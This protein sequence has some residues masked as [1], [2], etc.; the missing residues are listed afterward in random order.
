[1]GAGSAPHYLP[2]ASA[3]VLVFVAY[4][5]GAKLGLA[6][7]FEP[8]PISVLWPPNAIL[9]AA[10]LVAPLRWWPLLIVAALPAHLLAELQGGVP[11]AMVVCWFLSNVSEALIGAGFM[12]A[13]I[14]GR[15]DLDSLR[16]VAAFVGAAVLAAFLSSFLDSAFVRLV[17]WGTADYWELWRSRFSS[18]VLATLTVAPVIVTWASGSFASLQVFTPT[19]LAE[20]AVLVLGL[21]VAGALVFA[22]PV[23][24]SGALPALLYLPVPFLLW[25][26]LRFGAAGTSAAFM[27]VA[28]LAIWG[29][30]HGRG[31]FADGAPVENAQAVQVF[32][33]FV[34]LMVLVLAAVVQERR[35]SE[36]RA[37]EANERLAHIS[38]L[39]VVGELTASIAH[40][41]NQPLGAILNN[42]DAAE[43]LLR[44]EDPHLDELRNIIDDIRKDDMR[45]GEVIRHMRSLL[46]RR[47]LSVQPFDL[48]SAVEDVLHLVGA[49]LSR[50]SVTVE[51]VLT[52]LPIVHGD[53][54]HI[55]QVV[56][57]L[58]MN[59]V[60]AMKGV[61]PS[62]RRLEVVTA[63]AEDWGIEITVS[64]TG[65]GIPAGQME[66]LFQSFFTTKPDGMGL[67]LA[68]ARSIVEAHGGSIRA[69]NRRAGGACFRVCLPVRN[70]KEGWR[71]ARTFARGRR[72]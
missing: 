35:N 54:I 44:S 57:N 48:N 69:E 6:L 22:V 43:I 51:T 39:A 34:G 18:N 28:L 63:H 58:V 65:S 3:S 66:R 47:E 59:G 5:L 62:R 11:A 61:P 49:D 8:H 56:L 14:R 12:R 52:P 55:Q 9:L 53:Q 41:I 45:A 17:G 40:E 7:T 24:G 16:N 4:Y 29:A 1:V 30:G 13:V 72:T 2:L 50:H 32:L 23:V 27:L 33:T 26:S 67:G 70:R 19:R 20:A 64:D 36:E 37:K 15:P 68:I 42:A 60:D 31:P 25:A 10:L 21:L 38:R 46:R 71:G